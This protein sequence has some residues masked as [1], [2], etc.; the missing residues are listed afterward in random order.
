MNVNNK[1]ICPKCNGVGYSKLP[2]KDINV[3]CPICKGTGQLPQY[4]PSINVQQQINKPHVEEINKM[5]IDNLL[6][7][8]IK[9]HPE[10][11]LDG[12]QIQYE[13]KNKELFLLLKNKKYFNINNL[14][15]DKNIDY[16]ISFIIKDEYVRYLIKCCLDKK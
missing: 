11:F 9:K 14:V 8:C 3:A 12:Y 2:D 1:N 5:D 6:I 4:T 16:G 10:I 7:K 15:N 13:N